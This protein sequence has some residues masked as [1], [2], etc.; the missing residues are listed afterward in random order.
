MQ[1]HH[2]LLCEVVSGTGGAP[3]RS[4]P[5]G[6]LVTKM[7][8]GRHV[9]VT[10]QVREPNGLW[11]FIVEYFDDFPDTPQGWISDNSIRCEQ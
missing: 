7:E 9:H 10:K 11:D 5:N 3:V 8:D 4:R 2:V 1:H 6:A